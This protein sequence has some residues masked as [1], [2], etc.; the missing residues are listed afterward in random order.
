M[1]LDNPTQEL[2]HEQSARTLHEG[3]DTS[4]V[5][6]D[7]VLRNARELRANSDTVTLTGHEAV[8]QSRIGCDW[9]HVPDL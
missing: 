4:C 1:S 5:V 7:A 2:E 3:V 6:L 8:L 9:Q